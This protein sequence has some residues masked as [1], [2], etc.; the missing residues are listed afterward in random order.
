MRLSRLD[1]TR[2]GHFT[3]FSLDFGVCEPGKPDLHI[4]FGPNEAGKTTAFEAY[5]DLLFG[6][7]ARS[8]YNF[9][10]DYSN[11]RIGACL[12]IDGVEQELVRI[13]KSQNDLLDANG[14][15]VN[16][17][18]LARAL[19]GMNREQYR[20]MFSLDDETIEKGGDDILA[21]H[22]DLGQLLF[23]AA[24]GLSDL[25][26]VL[27]KARA[28][29]EGFHKSRAR[30]TFL[31]E[32]RRTLKDLDGQIRDI[33]LNASRFRALRTALET[34]KTGETSARKARD[35]LLGD[36]TRLDA[37]IECLPLLAER[38]GLHSDLETVKGFT[39]FKEAWLDLA[40][41]LRERE[42]AASAKSTAAQGALGKLRE[43]Q[44]K[45]VPDPDILAV[46]QEIEHLMEVPRPRALT[47]QGDLPKRKQELAE[48][49][50]EIDLAMKNLR[51]TEVDPAN[52][53]EP[54]LGKFERLAGD[55]EGAGEAL[56]NAL[57]EERNA[58]DELEKTAE[59]ENLESA[60]IPSVDDL[61]ALLDRL[62]SE[63]LTSQLRQANAAVDRE[64]NA[65]TD[66]LANLVPWHGDTDH[67][68]TALI[69]EDQARRIADEHGEL[70]DEHRTARQEFDKVAGELAGIQARI[71]TMKT[72]AVLYTDKD[73][74]EARAQRDAVWQAHIQSLTQ[75]TADKFQEELVRVDILQDAQLEAADRLAH[76]RELQIKEAELTAQRHHWKTQVAAHI[77]DLEAKQGEFFRLLEKLALPTSFDPRDLQPW[78]KAL[79]TAHKA[80]STLAQAKRDQTGALADITKAEAALRKVLN[81]APEAGDLPDLAHM[82]RQSLEDAGRAQ[83]RA[84][85]I[86]TAR[87]KLEKRKTDVKET[88]KCLADAKEEWRI[89][90]DVS[91]LKFESLSEFRDALPTL[92][93]LGPRFFEREKLSRRI[94][95]M[96]KDFDDFDKAVRDLNMRLGGDLDDEAFALAKRLQSRLKSA[97]QASHDLQNL[98]T[99]IGEQEEALI[100]ARKEL[101]NVAAIVDE[102]SPEFPDET[103]IKT[104]KE[105]LNAVSN[106]QKSDRLR[107]EIADLQ[108]RISL[109]LGRDDFAAALET[110]KGTDV[111]TATASLHVVKADLVQAETTL[112]GANRECGAAQ[113]ELAAVGGD[114]A[115]ARLQEKRQVLLLDI[116]EQA[117]KSLRLRLGV[118]LA[119]QA[120]A[121]YRDSH[122]SGMLAATEKA[123][124]KL[125]GGRYAR[126]ATQPDGQNEVLLAVRGV[127]NRS[128][129]AATMSKGTRFQL[130]LAL[131]LAGY[132]QFIA[133]GTTLPFI[134]DDILETFDNTRTSA[135]LD[136]LGDI[137]RSG[138]ALYFT[139]HQHVVD[140]ARERLGDGCQI[141]DLS[142]KQQLSSGNSREKSIGAN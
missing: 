44:T 86:Q 37:V 32:A 121:R 59:G 30:N 79:A 51:L 31:A 7:P 80:S 45:V 35:K 33:D 92:R 15:P 57:D 60:A 24:A 53:A 140:L 89:Q 27:D 108:R 134:A 139:H 83:E 42:V 46:R 101:K 55:V 141:H 52:L 98:N 20:A 58:R 76:L 90:A 142:A 85:A 127:D 88:E 123:F 107:E 111:P 128:I 12:E 71:G 112:E 10:H 11:M 122:R 110:L 103:T 129:S 106:A 87:T 40:R 14:N 43:T 9:L 38:G 16:P 3:D 93:T 1:L 34:A 132:G 115:V 81:V 125:T 91:P 63:T 2:F 117:R 97:E 84:R 120:L 28:A 99:Q 36:K 109:R 133:D 72:G 18:I 94:E 126:L 68:P 114:D 113:K 96:Q 48:L 25:S 105:L 75:K 39:V 8:N 61:R 65:V 54:V 131:R 78:L 22:G 67:L 137:S 130:Y 6:V 138:Q 82:A 102:M 21:S 74:E 26:G 62:E 73:R 70:K 118:L 56:N 50:A 4:I 5:L 100:T 66:A 136:L 116:T 95:A 17:T 49:S 77:Q 135:A 13:K 124:S 64:E 69:T 47:A 29:A 19:G 41:T 119:E 23:S 104:T